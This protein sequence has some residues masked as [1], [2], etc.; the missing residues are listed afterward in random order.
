[1]TRRRLPWRN[2]MDPYVVIALAIFLA[3]VLGAF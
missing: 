2:A 3:A 1:M